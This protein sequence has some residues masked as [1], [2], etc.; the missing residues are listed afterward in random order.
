MFR[1]P[2]FDRRWMS[3]ILVWKGIDVFSFCK[4]SLGPTSTIRTSPARRC[5]LAE[6]C[7]WGSWQRNLLVDQMTRE[8]GLA[9]VIEWYADIVVRDNGSSC[10]SWDKL[11]LSRDQRV[12][13]VLRGGASSLKHS[14]ITIATRRRK[15]IFHRNV[16]II[17]CRYKCLYCH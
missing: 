1:T 3:S 9:I 17:N 10:K 7:L 14:A 6:K 16:P 5:E 8:L 2:V 13:D 15:F 11:A 4:P 12:V